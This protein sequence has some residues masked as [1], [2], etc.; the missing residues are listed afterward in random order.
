[1]TTISIALATYNGERF[2][3]EQLDSLTRQSRLPNE[4]VVADDGSTDRTLQ[5]VRAFAGEAP[6]R[7]VVLPNQG[8]L[9][10]RANFMRCAEHCTSDLIAF[11]D[12]D[13]VWDKD[14]LAVVEHAIEP[15]TLLLQHDFRVVDSRLNTLAGDMQSIGI[16][17]G[18]R[19]APVLGLVQVFRRSL[20]ETWPLWSLST[21]HN[22]ASER[23]AHD[24]WVYFI[25]QALG[26][27]QLVPQAL[28]SYRQH[29]GNTCGL[30]RHGV[31]H[32]ALRPKAVVA[33]MLRGRPHSRKLKKD[34]IVEGLRL[35]RPAAESRM[36]VVAEIAK[37][38][39]WIADVPQLQREQRF[40]AGL[41]AYFER[42]LHSYQTRSRVGLL[43]SLLR[44]QP[45]YLSRGSRGLKD[46]LLD[47][48]LN[49]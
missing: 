26:R 40:Y 10:Y 8:R 32:D 25:A 18:E 43:A 36:A 3:G 17:A 11:C 5:I 46:F 16:S 41:S 6:F 14:K 33:D 23:M 44:S 2:L 47:A 1:M 21:D 49:A 45:D 35:Y 37:D 27:V 29:N 15:S 13:D 19:W 28:L 31:S 30:S 20:L 7:T 38:Q 48:A 34:V 42:R 9:G 24:Q 4:L 39:R 12:Q 22:R